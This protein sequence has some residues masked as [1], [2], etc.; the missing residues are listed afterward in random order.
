MIFFICLVFAAPAA[1][2]DEAAVK[3]LGDE[4]GEAKLEAINKLV[5]AGDVAAIPIFKAMQD[6]A[7]QRFNG[8]IVIVA[9]GKVTDALTGAAVN[10]PADKLEALVVN[11]RIRGALEGAIAALKLISPE[12]QERLAAAKAVADDASE[13]MLPLIKNALEKESDAEVKAL[14]VQARAMIEIKS[15]DATVRRAAVKLLGETKVPQ[16]KQILLILLQKNSDGSFGEPDA[17]VRDAAQE[18]IRTIELSFIVPQLL[19][20]LFS[21]VS[22]GSVLLLAALGLAITFGLMGIINMAHGEMLMLGAYA[23]Y[24]VQTWFR[25]YLPDFVD[26]YLVAA[27]PAAFLVSALVGVV[28]ER[29]VIRFLYGRPLET[30]LTTWGISLILIQFVRMLFGA[31]NVE[32]ANPAWMSG[33]FNLG[34]DVVLPYNRIVIIFFAALVVLLMW[35]LL[36]RT[37]LGLYVRAV[38]Q[39]RSMADC[40]GIPTPRVDWLTFGLGSGIAGLG[41]VAL[42]QIGNVGPDLGQSYIIDSFMVVVLGGVGQ[43]AGTIIAAVGLG[44]INKILEPFTGAVLGKIFVLVIIILFIQK[45]P[46]GMFALKGRTAEN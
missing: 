13:E 41:G 23:T 37:R 22:L 27:L 30:L 43:L 26:W 40:M 8:R 15:S 5:A 38:T 9:D 34:G 39:N 35:L 42:S 19:G 28:L 25:A 44:E 3:Q 2:L 21:G 12:R 16:A 6:D 45:R 20:A 1:A 17:G 11:N 7:L 32:V 31:Q 29:T 33:G 46:Q 24:A 4:D 36:T 18:A 10:A 14:L